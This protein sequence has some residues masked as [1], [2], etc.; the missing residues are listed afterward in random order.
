MSCDRTDF[1][2]LVCDRALAFH[3]SSLTEAG[4]KLQTGCG[5]AEHFKSFVSLFV[6]THVYL[7]ECFSLHVTTGRHIRRQ[8]PQPRSC[9]QLNEHS[10]RALIWNPLPG[11]LRNDFSCFLHRPD[12]G[13]AILNSQVQLAAEELKSKEPAQ[14]QNV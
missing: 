13:I 2:I 6:I 5:L 9:Q 1:L 3:L 11:L 12:L 14:A 7:Y 8:L 4:I 10:M